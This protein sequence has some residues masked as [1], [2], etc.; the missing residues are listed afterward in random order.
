MVNVNHLTI[1]EIE[2]RPSTITSLS[3]F[4]WA[5]R[6][7]SDAYIYN[8]YSGGV[9]SELGRGVN[10]YYHDALKDAKCFSGL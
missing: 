4:W 9:A 3:L 6:L 7:V 8:I 5:R 1:A 10:T 2:L